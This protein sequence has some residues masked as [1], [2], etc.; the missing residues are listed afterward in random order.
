MPPG[1]LG[2]IEPANRT[3]EQND[4]VAAA[5]GKFLAFAL[6]RPTVPKGTKILLSDFW[7][8]PEVLA[9]LN[10]ITFTGFRQL[11]GSCVG[12][13]DGDAVFTLACIQRMVSDAPTRAFIPWWPTSYGRSRAR[14]GING[15]G[16]GSIDSVMGQVMVDEGVDDVIATQFDTIDGFALSGSTELKWSNGNSSLVTARLTHTK[17]YPMGG[18]APLYDVDGIA[19]AVINGYP[20]LDG[21]N[22][23]VGSGHVNQ[24]GISLG[25]YDGRGGHSTTILGYWEHETLGPLYLYHNQ[26]AGTTYPADTS[27]KPRCSTWMLEASLRQLFANGG[28]QGE[29]MLF[30]HLNY[31]PAQPRVLDWA[32]I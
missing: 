20:V 12:V 3:K 1:P 7:T 30:S 24:Q 23:Y 2:W 14:A 28:D 15:Q 4:A 13:S 19:A 26:W 27:G 11:T 17:Q 8:K 5:Q 21:C 16:E 32:Q 9:D 29:T 25:T 10:G 6:A 31:V 22:N 18:M